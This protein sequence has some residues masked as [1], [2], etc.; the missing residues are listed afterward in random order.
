MATELNYD[1]G[2]GS[3]ILDCGRRG[4]NNFLAKD[5]AR[6]HDNI[7]SSGYRERVIEAADV[8]VSF[9]MP[10]L[11]VG[12][13]Y[14]SWAKFYRWALAGNQFNFAPNYPASMAIYDAVLEQLSFEPKRVGIGRYALD[15][16]IR[17]LPGSRAPAD[18][19][20]VMQ[21]FWGLS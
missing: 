11:L 7:S 2:T 18:A 8:L 12:D 10:A 13:D 6:A 17:I 21:A 14:E 5:T 1:P 20:E 16:M 3:I 9:T 15:V 19:G 4:V